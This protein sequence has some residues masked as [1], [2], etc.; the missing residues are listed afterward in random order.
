MQLLCRYGVG[1]DGL[2]DNLSESEILE[3]IEGTFKC[4]E[5]S[6]NAGVA[7]GQALMNKASREIVSA[8]GAALFTTLF[9]LFFCPTFTGELSSCTWQ[10]FTGVRD[11]RLS[12]R[13]PNFRED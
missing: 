4:I 9:I 11:V 6:A 3:L 1:S 8:V 10:T 5:G 2:W 13:R 7:E 12:L